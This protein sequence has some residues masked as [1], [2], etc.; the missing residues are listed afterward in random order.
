MT[1]GHRVLYAKLRPQG[2]DIAALCQQERKIFV[3]YPAWRRGMPA[4]ARP[5]PEHLI[6]VGLRV[7]RIDASELSE[8]IEA[9]KR[10]SY[11]QAVNAQRT[12]I[13]QVGPG[14]LA[15]IPRLGDGIVYVAEI[16]S[17]FQVFDPTTWAGRYLDERRN[18][19][20]PVD[21]E[22]SHVGDVMQGWDT[23]DWTPVPFAAMPRWISQRVLARNTLGL[24]DRAED[25]RNA[26]D[27]VRAIVLSGAS[28]SRTP[29]SSP[30]E[31][32]GRM[33]DLLSPSSFEHLC[34]DLMQLENPGEIW[35]HV[36]GSGDGGADGLGYGPDGRV[37]A[38]L[39][40]KYQWPSEVADPRR[41]SAD[42]RSSTRLVMASLVHDGRRPQNVPEGAV[43]LGSAEVADLLLKHRKRLPIALTLGIDGAF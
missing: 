13:L 21:N 40:C 5:S 28:M 30:S 7:E 1:A 36:G 10:K 33:H 23:G 25:G 8:S 18:A 32:V 14:S 38:V 27:V 29:V 20:L 31:V 22:L 16:L 9:P 4:T 35:T 34:V 2:A 17:R 43:W 11:A 19:R 6:D 41:L 39:Q 3:G 15:M 24:V 12:R 37:A 26:W 42:S